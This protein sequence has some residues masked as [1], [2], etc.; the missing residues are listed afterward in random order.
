MKLDLKGLTESELMK[1]AELV[2]INAKKGRVCKIS[3]LNKI[4]VKGDKSPSF[5]NFYS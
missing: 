5:L 2:Y 4:G 3:E 1:L